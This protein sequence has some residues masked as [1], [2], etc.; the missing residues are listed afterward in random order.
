MKYLKS[1]LSLLQGMS[2]TLPS[3]YLMRSVES[4]TYLTNLL[5]QWQ[6]SI[7]LVLYYN[8]TSMIEKAKIEDLVTAFPKLTVIPYPMEGNSVPVNHLKNLGI[9]AVKTTHFIVTDINYYPS[10]KSVY[11]S[12]KIMSRELIP[13]FECHSRLPLERSLFCRCDSCL[14]VVSQRVYYILSKRKV[15]WMT[16]WSRQRVV[17]DCNWTLHSLIRIDCTPRLV[18]FTFPNLSI[19]HVN[20]VNYYV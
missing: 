16:W 9:N 2:A 4:Y 13:H 5:K 11:S 15:R 19:N 17:G 14:W 12:R 6:G 7:I 10:S 1:P 3:P 20:Y 8:S 18:K